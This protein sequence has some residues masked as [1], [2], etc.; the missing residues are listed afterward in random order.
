MKKCE[1][2]RGGGHQ[3]KRAGKSRKY[4]ELEGKKA[5]R[6]GK[7]DQQTAGTYGS[8]GGKQAYGGKGQL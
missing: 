6:E 7:E 8:E 2:L 5:K 3:N 1:N 4:T